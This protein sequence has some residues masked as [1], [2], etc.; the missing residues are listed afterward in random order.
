[1]AYSL[2]SPTYLC[3]AASEKTSDEH[4]RVLFLMRAW[5]LGT[6]SGAADQ[7]IDFLSSRDGLLRGCCD[8]VGATSCIGPK[9]TT[10]GSGTVLLDDLTSTLLRLALAL[11]RH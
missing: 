1:M 2:N 3:A 6:S 11:A 8:G 4:S 10:G 9:P 5:D 7:S